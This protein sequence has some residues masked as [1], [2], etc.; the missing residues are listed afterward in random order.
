MNST[1]LK[2]IE[3]KSIVWF[4][5]SNQYI[6]LEPLA[7]R[8]AHDLHLKKNIEQIALQLEKD[9]TLPVKKGIDFITN[10][11][12]KIV[13][14]NQ[15]KK[16]EAPATNKGDFQKPN[17]FQFVKH[18]KINDKI[19]KT[20]FSN[21]LELSLIHPKFAHLETISSNNIHF[22]FQ[23]FSNSNC[24]HLVV[25]N[26]FIGSWNKENSHYFQGKF[27]MKIIEAVYEKSEDKWIG[28]FHA[29][30]IKK[31]EKSILILGDS[32]YGK[33]TSLA[34][35]QANGFDCVADDFVPVDQ[36][37]N[38]YS[39]PAGISIKKKSLE[40]LLPHY[41]T[42]ER[43]TEFHYEKANKTVR[44]LSPKTTYCRKPTPCN[45]LVFIKY[46]KEV[47]FKFNTVSNIKAFESL[48][49]DSWISS[50]PKNVSIFLDWFASLPC[51]QLTYSN[52]EKMI[53][54]VKQLFKN[55]L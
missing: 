45:A 39:F 1:I 16:N 6:V 32:G 50:I 21:E 5:N 38:V 44:Y 2:E 40:V 52:N 19:I 47:D 14:P 7:A 4:Q 49:P 27:S 53:N 22:S 55:E 34:L 9:L 51:Y 28:V 17:S 18:Y 30:A 11:N 26:E 24:I 29:S 37:K 41:P 36:N 43:L 15:K 33:S 23:I 54:S 12:R 42:L 48:I 3:S 35:L 10:V 13:I 8:I 46:D 25:D 31:K 20:E